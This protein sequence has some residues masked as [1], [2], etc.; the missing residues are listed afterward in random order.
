[1]KTT[2]RLASL[3]AL[4]VLLIAS[5]ATAQAVATNFDELRLKI[6]SGDAIYV[7]DETGRE[8]RGRVLDLSPSVL[9]V[10]FD[11]QPADLTESGVQRIRQRRPDPLWTGAA[12][13]GGI[14][15][16][17]GV[18]A[19]AF[20]EDCSHNSSSGGCIGPVLMVT[21]AYAAIGV[22]IDAL[23]QGRKPIYERR[24]A[25]RVRVEPLAPPRGVGVRLV[26]SPR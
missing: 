12:I 16:G 24:A 22:G 15:L 4:L 18:A 6:K 7:T 3:S 13:G 19:A 2:L 17:L 26:I 23:I 21:G 25:G 20:S 10:A 5:T 11:G 9:R 14:G 1:M 8:R